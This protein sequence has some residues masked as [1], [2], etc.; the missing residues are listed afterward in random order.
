MSAD[1]PA[2]HAT[3]IQDERNY[4]ENAICETNKGVSKKVGWQQNPVQVVF[5]QNA[6]LY[7]TEHEDDHSRIINMFTN[8][9]YTSINCNSSDIR[10]AANANILEL[11]HFWRRKLK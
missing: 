2:K 4:I 3:I 1:T 6:Y 7:N 8:Y 10:H 5:V 11:R 9:R